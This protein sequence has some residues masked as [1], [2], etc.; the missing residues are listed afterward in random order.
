M[1]RKKKECRDKDEDNLPTEPVQTKPVDIARPSGIH[2]INEIDMLS[3]CDRF[4][5]TTGNFTGQQEMVTENAEYG[6]FA[7]ACVHG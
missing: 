3:D 7:A 2:N 4:T 1:R 5:A 6:D